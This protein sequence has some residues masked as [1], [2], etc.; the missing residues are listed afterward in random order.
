[1]E[2]RLQTATSSGEE[3]SRISVQRFEHLITPR[4]FWLLLRFAASLYRMYGI[5]FSTCASRIAN[6]SSRAFTTRRAA[7]LASYASYLARNS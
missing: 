4:F 1:M 7:P 3:Y 2:A 6:H 5:P